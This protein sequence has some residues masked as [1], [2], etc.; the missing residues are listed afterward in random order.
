MNTYMQFCDLHQVPYLAPGVYDLL[1]Y[2]LFLKDRLKSVNS[3]MNYFSTVKLWVIAAKGNV[4]VF[5]AHEISLMKRGLIKNSTHEPAK[6]PIISPEELAMVVAHMRS[7]DPCPHV[8]PAAL[9]MFFTLARQCNIV[10]TSE[11]TSSCPHLLRYRDVKVYKGDLYVTI[12]STKTHFAS[13]PSIIFKIP[14]I[15]FSVC[16]PVTAW[17][18]YIHTVNILPDSPALV[19]PS[20]EALTAKILLRALKL[21]CVEI[22]GSDRDVTLHSIR[23]G[24]TQACQS[25]G[26]S[27]ENIMAAGMWRSGAVNTYLQDTLISSAPAAL[28]KLFGE[29]C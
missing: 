11:D 21:T 2:L 20:G 12:R 5:N 14:S 7:L 10:A 22:F 4:D 29:R 16:C 15:L 6:A 18:N 1:S 28:A 27:I 23:R 3:I 17:H 13:Y 19:L 8:L 26:L 25:S 9:L 24:A